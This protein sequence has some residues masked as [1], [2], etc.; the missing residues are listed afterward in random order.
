VIAAWTGGT[1]VVVGGGGGGGW[2]VGGGG[3][4]VPDVPLAEGVP[5]ADGAVVVD[6]ADDALEPGPALLF[7]APPVLSVADVLDPF[8]VGFVVVDSPPADR[9]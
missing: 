6:V 7:E 1:V 8:P 2:V 5:G 3:L 4:T 9:R